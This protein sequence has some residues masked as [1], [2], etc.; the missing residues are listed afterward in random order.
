MINF[1]INILFH[2]FQTQGY[3][4]ITIYN[5]ICYKIFIMYLNKNLIKNIN[6]NII[7]VLIKVFLQIETYKKINICN[8]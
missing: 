4:F 8:I 7:V 2:T 5:M 3:L 1:Q 6:I